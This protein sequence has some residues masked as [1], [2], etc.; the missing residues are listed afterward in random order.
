MKTN[1]N[2]NLQHTT[3]TIDIISFAYITLYKYLAYF[4][5]IKDKDNDNIN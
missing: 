5:A 1:P 3:K 4:K 2:L